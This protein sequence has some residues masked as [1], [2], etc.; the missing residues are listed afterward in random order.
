MK[1]RGRMRPTR[2]NRKWGD[3]FRMF[4]D[5]GPRWADMFSWRAVIRRSGF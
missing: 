2:R 3:V 1:K 5:C 4:H